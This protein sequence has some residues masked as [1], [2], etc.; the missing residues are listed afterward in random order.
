VE[1]DTVTISTRYLFSDDSLGNINAK[2]NQHQEA[3]AGRFKFDPAG[4]VAI[5][6]GLLS[7]SNF[8]GGWNDTGLGG[9][10][11]GSANIYLKQLYLSVQPVKGLEF[12]Y[13]SF[14]VLK[15]ESTDITSYANPGYL[16]GERVIVERPQDL[17]FDQIAVTYAYLGDYFTPNVNKRYHRLKQSN[18]HQFLV[19][20]KI[21]NRAVVSTDY[22]FQDGAETMREAVSINAKELRV[23]DTFRF[24]NYQRTDVN[25]AYGFAV[26]GE[27]KLFNRLTLG[28]GFAQVDR[29]FGPF[30]SDA[31]FDG[32]RVF[33]SGH[34]EI[35]PEFGI[36][37]HYN[38][39][40]ANNYLV[41]NRTH[42]EI[43]FHYDLLKSLRRTGIF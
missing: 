20:K 8:A 3:I 22:T 4:K 14:G 35:S 41:G 39:A 34:V 10:G 25:S 9:R 29:N 5:N 2:Q 27:K 23:I 12:Q 15:G 6:A 36:S 13:G 40:V 42:F 38:R 37:T 43:A 30:N 7:G 16:V 17:F 11:R 18:Y 32:R 1:L 28:G 19:S 33:V 21:G 24:E 31:F 26:S